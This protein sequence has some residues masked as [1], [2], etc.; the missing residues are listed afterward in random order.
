MEEFIAKVLTLG[1]LVLILLARVLDISIRLYKNRDDREGAPHRDGERV[2]GGDG[3]EPD[4]V[5]IHQREL[6]ASAP[7]IERPRGSGSDSELH[8]G[9]RGE[10]ETD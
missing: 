1:A 5:G 8:R 10:E 9:D 2:D 7:F 4:P 3:Y 6:S